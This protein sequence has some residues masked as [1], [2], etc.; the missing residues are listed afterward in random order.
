M[1]AV[2]RTGGKQYTVKPG[3]VLQIEKVEN[4]LGSEF[5]VSDV[6]VVGGEQTLIG[7]PLVKNAKV[8][9]VVTKQARTRKITVFKKKR[10]QSYRKFKNHKQMFTEVF[11]KSITSP[12]GKSVKADSQPKI[13]DIA[14]ARV[15][16]IETKKIDAR[17]RRENKGEEAPVE[18]KA[19]TVKKVAKKATAKKTKKTGKKA[20]PKKAAKKTKKA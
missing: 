12:D 1:Y 6:L 15:E 4:G 5:D 17:A 10:R 14:A 3:D 2:I 16:R 19:K 11:V 8:T 13:V 20:A 18:K 7:Q 9:L